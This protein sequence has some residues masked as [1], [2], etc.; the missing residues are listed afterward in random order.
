MRRRSGPANQVVAFFM[1]DQYLELDVR[2]PSARNPDLQI[3]GRKG[4]ARVGCQIFIGTERQDAKNAADLRSAERRGF[5]LA[6]RAELAGALLDNYGGGFT[7]K[8]C[9]A[10]ARPPP[11]REKAAERSRL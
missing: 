2:N 10:R 4:R 8:R 6:E 7:P 1:R 3:I 9:G 5:C 11:G